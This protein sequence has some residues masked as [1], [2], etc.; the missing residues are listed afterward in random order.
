MARGAEGMG[1]E[2]YHSPL[3]TRCLSRLT[4][5]PLQTIEPRKVRE[6]FSSLTGRK[7]KMTDD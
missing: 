5:W 7:L 4:V 2:I 6:G 1:M 3:A